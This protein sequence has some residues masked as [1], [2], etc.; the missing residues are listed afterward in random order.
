MQ[1]DV[2]SENTPAQEGNL[3]QLRT[4]KKKKRHL[5]RTAQLRASN[6]K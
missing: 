4:K 3:H 5:K 2:E 6:W 1:T